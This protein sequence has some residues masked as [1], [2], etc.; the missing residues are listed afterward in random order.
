LSAG[1]REAISAIHAEAK[2]PGGDIYALERIKG[3]VHASIMRYT[4]NAGTRTMPS[5]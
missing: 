5:K 4:L 1:D 3:G 2:G